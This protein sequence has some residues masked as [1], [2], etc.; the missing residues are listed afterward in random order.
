[1]NSKKGYEFE[2]KDIRYVWYPY[3]PAGDYTVLMAAGGTG[4]TYFA[5]GI[6]ATISK[7]EALP[8]PDEYKSK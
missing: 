3:I 7:G 2:K 6:A 8:V 1:M 4:K 5:C